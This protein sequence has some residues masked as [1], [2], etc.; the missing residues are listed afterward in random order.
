MVKSWTRMVKGWDCR[1]S[2]LIYKNWRGPRVELET[3]MKRRTFLKRQVVLLAF[4]PPGVMVALSVFLQSR[5]RATAS[6]GLSA[7]LDQ[8]QCRRCLRA[9]LLTWVNTT[10]L[11]SSCA[12]SYQQVG[13]RLGVLHSRYMARC[14]GHQ[15]CAW[16]SLQARDGSSDLQYHGQ[17]ASTSSRCL[18]SRW[19]VVP[20]SCVACCSSNAAWE[21]NEAVPTTGSPQG[22]ACGPHVATEAGGSGLRGQDASPGGLPRQTETTQWALW[23]LPAWQLHRR[24]QPMPVDN[25]TGNEAFQMWALHIAGITA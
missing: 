21:A 11:I 10:A 16:V 23:V 9:P 8:N 14:Q 5:C 15:A 13:T 7:W 18:T 24:L 17:T 12:Y 1:N 20:P 22:A 25:A 6:L 19:L 4:H 2:P 3:G